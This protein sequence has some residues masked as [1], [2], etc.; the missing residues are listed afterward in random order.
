MTVIVEVTVC[1]G[2]LHV[3]SD[4]EGAAVGL[5]T[6]AGNE[7]G[8]SSLLPPSFAALSH[9]NWN[10]IL[11]SLSQLGSSLVQA[12]SQPAGQGMALYVPS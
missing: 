10:I 11:A 9:R 6:T 5:G 2:L 4:G 7:V 3:P 12:A 1:F 8:M